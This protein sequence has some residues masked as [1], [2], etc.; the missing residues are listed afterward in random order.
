MADSLPFH[1][2]IQAGF[3][4]LVRIYRGGFG[5]TGGHTFHAVASTGVPTTMILSAMTEGLQ[6]PAAGG[7]TCPGSGYCGRGLAASG[8]TD[9][10]DS[11]AAP[12]HLAA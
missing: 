7:M 6:L 5:V 2:F 4:T 1:P 12:C 11:R 8:G 3:Y 9:A 10:E